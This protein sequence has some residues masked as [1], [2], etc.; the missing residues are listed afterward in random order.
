MDNPSTNPYW[1]EVFN[2]QDNQLFDL[3]VSY[4]GDNVTVDVKTYLGEAPAEIVRDSGWNNRI[5]EVE[6][7]DGS[8]ANPLSLK[9]TSE[10]YYVSSNANFL[11]RQVSTGRLNTQ[12]YEYFN[13]LIGEA[14]NEK[15]TSQ[16]SKGR[17]N[18]Q[19]IDDIYNATGGSF[20]DI[21]SGTTT[22]AHDMIKDILED[23]ATY[24]IA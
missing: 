21:S 24:I 10:D 15:S 19:V 22:T 3:T 11:G 23:F 18:T 7:G 12:E 4:D 14:I 16:S 2:G 1:D 20:T 17:S 8:E 13:L 9:Q 6:V 5:V